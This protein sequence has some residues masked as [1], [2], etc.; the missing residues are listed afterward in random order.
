MAQV[1]VLREFLEKQ[2]GFL[3]IILLKQGLANDE[4]GLIS[5]IPFAPLADENSGDFISH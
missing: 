1:Q 5:N 3:L 2:R 4:I